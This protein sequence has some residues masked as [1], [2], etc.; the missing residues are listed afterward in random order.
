MAR[1]T[2]TRL[3]VRL[4]LRRTQTAW[5][6]SS[7]AN[8]IDNISRS[9]TGS[10][11]IA[12]GELLLRGGTPSQGS[13]ARRCSRRRYPHGR[14]SS[15][16]ANAPAVLGC[17]PSSRRI[18][19]VARRAAIPSRWLPVPAARFPDGCPRSGL[20]PIARAQAPTEQAAEVTGEMLT[21]LPVVISQSIEVGLVELKTGGS[22][23]RLHGGRSNHIS[24]FLGFW[25]HPAS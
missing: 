17:R 25:G 2:R 20:D 5:A 7:S 22:S 9:R 24:C 15:K 23:I 12:P 6:A 3:Y 4:T 21:G 8:T 11:S 13:N 10:D 19:A 1:C 16:S 18:P 14:A